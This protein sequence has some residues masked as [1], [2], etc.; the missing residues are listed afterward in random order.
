[1]QEINTLE[2]QASRA[3]QAGLQDEALRYWG[4]ILA[5]DPNH[6]RT[7][8]SMGH[9]AFRKGDFKS[10]RAAF[11]R[12]ADA[13]GGASQQW[14]NLALA[15]RSLADERAEEAA[16]RRALEIDPSDLLG[17]VLRGNLLERQGK[18]HQAAAV[19]SAAAVVAP[20]FERLH[21]DLRGAVSHA[22]KFREIYDG[23]CAE[24]MG[25]YLEPQTQAFAE[26]DLKRFRDS[27]D[28]LVGRRKRY[29]SRSEHFHFTGLPTVEFFARK[30]FPWLDAFESATDE[31]REE[32]LAVLEADDGFTPY[33]T[34]PPGLPL[35]QWAELNN[36]PDWS[37]FHL[38]KSGK[39]VPENAAKCPKT[40]ALLAQ[41]PQP[42]QEGRTPAAMFSLLK[43]NTRIPPHG[44]VSNTRLVTHVPLIIPAGCGFRVGN[45]TREWE[46]GKAWVFD[47]TINHEA[48]NN[49]DKLRVVLI[50]DIWH[51]L[52]SEAER[53]LVSAMNRGMNEFAAG[54]VAI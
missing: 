54:N 16:L 39:L 30:D 12:V 20:P 13:D 36:S 42:D 31:I 47:D 17:L 53:A 34:Y 27:F 15:C 2:A 52:L 19:Y 1:M 38:Y 28:I 26:A 5:L 8:T 10:A 3:M 11:Q 4:R 51:P 45:E 33:I 40:M 32:F 24:F 29:D 37:A 7:L 22:A 18:P 46:P 14:I 6:G 50:F 23:K 49:S 9:H 43:P 41:A 44:G 48:W 21:P 25:R 35:N